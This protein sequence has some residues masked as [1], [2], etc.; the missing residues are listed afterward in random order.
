MKATAPSREYSRPAVNESSKHL[1]VLPKKRCDLPR[2][3]RFPR[4]LCSSVVSARQPDQIEID[5][6]PS[7][8]VDYLMCQVD[9]KSQIVT[10]RD[11]THR[12]LLHIT[13]TRDEG[14]RT[15][16]GPEFTQLVH[17]QIGFDS[18]AHVLRRDSLPDHIGNITR[19]V[20]E[21]TDVDRRVMGEGQ[22]TYARADAGPQD[23]D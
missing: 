5:S 22:K 10:R 9:W 7:Y 2:V 11:E 1:Q 12:A 13:Q 8:F 21:N 14:H 6:V 17:R 18:G 20:I 19:H 15:N 3:E 23:T 4:H 16:R